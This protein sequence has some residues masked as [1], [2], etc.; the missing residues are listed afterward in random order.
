MSD[1]NKEMMARLDEFLLEVQKPSR[2]I[3]GEH[4][5]V[6][7]DRSQVDIRF[8]FCFPDTYEIGMSHLGMKILYGL[9]NAVPNYWCERVFMP[10]PDMEEQMRRRNIPLYALESLDPIKDFDFIG[11]TLQYEMSYTNILEML[12]LA[13]VP[14]LAKDRTG[15]T[16]IVMA[17][18]PCVCN[19]EPLAD[20]FD[21]FAIG[22]GEEM[23]LEFMRLMEQCKKEGTTR[24]EFLRRAAQIEGIYVP[25]LYDVDYNPDGTVKSIT[26]KDGAPAKVTKRIIKDFD[27][28]YTPDNFV[29]P[30][31]QIVH[32]RA[33]VEVLRGCIR[34][35]RFCQAG[36]IYRP[37]R[38]KNKDTI[39]ANTKALCDNTGYDE[40]S[41]SSLSTGDYKD[42]V[43]LL[44]D[45]TDY[46]TAEKINLSLPSLRI[47]RFSD[48]V[49]K[50][51]TDVRKSGLTF[52]P[53][54]GTQRIRDVINKNVTE[55]NVMDSVRTAF[56]GG[57]TN[58]KLYFM[59]GL[60]T[61]TL[62]DIKGVY[63][64]ARAV[65]EE[66]YATPNHAK[67]RPGVAVSL[68]TFIPKPFTPFEFEP[69]LDEAS[70]RERQR[71]L[72]T[73][74]TDRKI[75]ISYPSYELSL[76]EA[77]LA[78]GD[79]RLGKAVYLAWQKGCK[80]DGW[81]E[82]FKFDAWIEAIKECGLD[83]A[84]YANRRRSYDEVAPWSHIDMLV[85]RE[86]LIEENKRAHL[87]LTTPNCREKCS[88]CG[89]AKC[90]GG[91]VCRA[92]R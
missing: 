57:Y 59:M 32:D 20:F 45:L 48:E 56:E 46:T 2:Y 89:V 42:I 47:D 71:Y 4:G 41:L 55:Q 27:K 10:L 50:K 69:Q 35:C 74:N 68:S 54:G 39:L 88:N 28:V 67:G 75:T 14:V 16:P 44:S 37:Y 77:V 73:I 66:F 79:R 82:H 3:G 24:Q 11:F 53:E 63:D 72:K 1:T 21:F 87:G 83:P 90:V 81:D 25:S 17:G 60:P 19:P 64:L 34:G 65:I 51:I 86:F 43:G 7:K 62:E 61:E 91:D 6:I 52:A 15:L 49:V 85:S 22:E 5:A 38:E 9:K 84:F 8:A 23:N 26:P 31:T 40:V 18:G 29:V 36:F 78:R 76:I 80:L 13:G 30:F 70:V 33:V 12:D 92:I 58:I